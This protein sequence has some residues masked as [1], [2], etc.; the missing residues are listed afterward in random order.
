MNKEYKKSAA[1]KRS[2]ELLAAFKAAG[3]KSINIYP[4]DDG[5]GIEQAE[6]YYAELCKLLEGIKNGDG[7]KLVFND[8]RKKELN[9]DEHAPKVAVRMNDIVNKRG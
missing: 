4:S 1:Y 9:I 8:S 2:E 3:L 6:A 5:I 7:S